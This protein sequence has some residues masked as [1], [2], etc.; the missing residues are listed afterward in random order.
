MFIQMRINLN[1]EDKPLSKPLFKRAGK[2]LKIYL[3]LLQIFLIQEDSPPT[4]EGIGTLHHLDKI[5]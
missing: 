2:P 3:K 4:L 5:R 1:W